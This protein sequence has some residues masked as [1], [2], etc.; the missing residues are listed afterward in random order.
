M[1]ADEIES[2][3]R[4]I[5]EN[6]VQRKLGEKPGHGAA[7]R[8][9]QRTGVVGCRAAVGGRSAVVRMGVLSRGR[10]I[11]TRGVGLRG[12]G[13]VR[14]A[15]ITRNDSRER[16]RLEYQPGGH[17]HAKVSADGSHDSSPA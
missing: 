10:C 17:I 7:A 5:A 14:R 11:V 3:L 4:P 1:R 6:A 13:P 15:A 16:R 12:C 9:P 8:A 2:K